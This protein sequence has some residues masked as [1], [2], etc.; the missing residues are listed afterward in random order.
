MPA[1]APVVVEEPKVEAVAPPAK[2]EPT[3]EVAAA[4]AEE[5]AV[6]EEAAIVVPPPAP[7]VEAEG[8]IMFAFPRRF[9][10]LHPAWVVVLRRIYIQIY[11]Y[12]FTFGTKRLIVPSS[13]TLTPDR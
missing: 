11:I 2:V 6:V 13:Y 8:E 7:K 12:S 3:E 4:V 5:V 9:V 1:P 10:F